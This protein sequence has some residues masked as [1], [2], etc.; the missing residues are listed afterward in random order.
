[1]CI[2]VLGE[3]EAAEASG[4]RLFDIRGRICPGVERMA[5]MYVLVVK[6]H[7]I[8]PQGPHEYPSS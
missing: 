2:E 3:R 4:E 1:M 6:R 8:S 7:E 5:G